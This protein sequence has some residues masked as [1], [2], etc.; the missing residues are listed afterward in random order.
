MIII[1]MMMMLI[2]IIITINHNLDRS[3]RKVPTMN[4]GFH[5][6]DC[7]ARLYVPRKDEGTGLISVEDCVN[8]A[9][10][11]LESHV[12][13]SKEELLKTVRREGVE[14]QETAA[15]FTVNPGQAYPPRIH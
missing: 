14:S 6:R 3:T 8:E 5:P 2:I 12:L 10:M 1:M 15:G 9:S 7:V 13:S 4:G 11:S